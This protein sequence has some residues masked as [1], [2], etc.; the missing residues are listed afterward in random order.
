MRRAGTSGLGMDL[1]A[2]RGPLLPVKPREYLFGFFNERTVREPQSKEKLTSAQNL[3]CHRESE[4]VKAACDW[5]DKTNG[6]H[7]GSPTP[8]HLWIPWNCNISST[9]DTA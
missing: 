7:G 5:Q 2:R 4:G 6:K 3:V 8:P 1:L 9:K